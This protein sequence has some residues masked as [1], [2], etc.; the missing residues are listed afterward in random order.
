[1]VEGAKLVVPI[2]IACI[3]AEIG[4]TIGREKKLGKGLGS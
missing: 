4:T 2:P 1:M 3:I